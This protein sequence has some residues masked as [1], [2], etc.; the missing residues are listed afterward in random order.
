MPT[1]EYECPGEGIVREI[2][3]PF[4]H[5]TPLCSTCG[6]KMVRVYNAPPVHF[7]GTGFYKIGRAHV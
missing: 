2:Y 6:A 4:E 7:K 5:D 1:Y 3:L